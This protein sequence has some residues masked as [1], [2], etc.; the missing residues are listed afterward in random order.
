MLGGEGRSRE[1]SEGEPSSS[2]SSE[3][4]GPTTLHCA[5]FQLHTFSAPGLLFSFTKGEFCVLRKTFF[6]TMND[7]DER[8]KTLDLKY[9]LTLF[10]D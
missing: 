6:K 7:C 4:P 2:S 3:L 9:N 1:R 8:Y 5:T 10:I